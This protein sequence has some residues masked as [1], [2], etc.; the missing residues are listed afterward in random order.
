MKRRR[1]WE[2]PRKDGR[3]PQQRGWTRD[4]K[5]HPTRVLAEQFSSMEHDAFRVPY[6][7]DKAPEDEFHGQA[8]KTV[9]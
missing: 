5:R 4:P 1:G 6:L 3:A 8:V 2:A 7:S 9:A